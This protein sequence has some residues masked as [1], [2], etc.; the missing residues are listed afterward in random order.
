MASGGQLARGAPDTSSH[1][2]ASDGSGGLRTWGCVSPVILAHRVGI[3]L[4][5]GQE[6]Q[7][8]KV[9][10]LGSS[11][12][13]VAGLEGEGKGGEDPPLPGPLPGHT[14]E[15]RSPPGSFEVPRGSFRD[16]VMWGSG[17]PPW[18]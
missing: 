16:R 18:E 9:G 4:F 1:G 11:L 8:F 12:L 14:L 13:M 17:W 2:V 10:V 5:G 7:P 3:H 15:V 6:V